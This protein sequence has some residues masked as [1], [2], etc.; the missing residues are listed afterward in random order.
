M[1][2]RK[3]TASPASRSP[4]G[5]SVFQLRL[6]APARGGPQNERPGGTTATRL[7]HTRTCARP[8][9]PQ[10]QKDRTVSQ[11]KYQSPRRATPLCRLARPRAPHPPRDPETHPCTKRTPHRSTA[12]P[13]SPVVPGRGARQA[14]RPAYHPR[15]SHTHAVT[16][17]MAAALATNAAPT[18]PHNSRDGTHAGPVAAEWWQP[19]RRSAPR[20]GIRRPGSEGRRHATPSSGCNAAVEPHP[21]GRS[22]QRPGRARRSNDDAG[23]H[24]QP[25]DEQRY[26]PKR[27]TVAA[28]RLWTARRSAAPPRAAHG[29]VTRGRL[30]ASASQTK[31]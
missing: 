14:A 30:A 15:Q 13:A 17:L 10:P 11:G 28:A 9:H 12:L 6:R 3:S 4:A 7:P 26:L 2:A 1:E 16:S 18:T 24:W 27:K 5:R 8:Y 23:R 25:N 22:T 19:P 29:I 21:L 20:E 31:W